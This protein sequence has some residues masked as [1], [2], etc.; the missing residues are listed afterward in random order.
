MIRIPIRSCSTRA[1]IRASKI[2]PRSFATSSLVPPTTR[3]SRLLPDS[4]STSVDPNYGLGPSAAK[5]DVPQTGL[6]G[7]AG[8]IL[9]ESGG[10]VV[11][12]QDQ[13]GGRK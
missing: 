2:S 10:A 6:I 7:A 9:A 12:M 8:G 1:A 11:L 3:I 13:I 4:R 5:E